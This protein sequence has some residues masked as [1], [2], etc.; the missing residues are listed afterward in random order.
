VS[1]Q[2]A[3]ASEESHFGRF[4]RLACEARSLAEKRACREAGGVM[5]VQ[6]IPS[7]SLSLKECFSHMASIWRNIQPDVRVVKIGLPRRDSTSSS[8]IG[9][10]KVPID[11]IKGRRGT[12]AAI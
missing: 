12:A 1:V 2:G 7:L 4:P 11:I 8:S 6:K 9:I 3:R 10:L 5:R